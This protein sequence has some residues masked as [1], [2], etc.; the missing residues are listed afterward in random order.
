MLC[1]KTAKGPVGGY[2]SVILKLSY[3][4]EDADVVKQGAI[5]C[6]TPPTV[7]HSESPEQMQKTKTHHPSGKKGEFQLETVLL[8]HRT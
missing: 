2:V 6:V 4:T 1:T 7:V 5:M 3:E 8:Y